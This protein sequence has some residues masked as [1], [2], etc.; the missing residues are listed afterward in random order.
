MY[1]ISYCGPSLGHSDL[2]NLQST[3]PKNGCILIWRLI[4]RGFYIFSSIKFQIKLCSLIA[5]PSYLPWT[6]CDQTS[7]CTTSYLYLILKWLIMTLRW[8][9]LYISLEN[10]HPQLWHHS[11]LGMIDF[12]NFESAL[13]EDSCLWTW[14]VMA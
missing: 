10:L 11:T 6:W 2:N 12:S 5:A 7:I 4:L 9:F 1:M 3:L 13:P 8:F 14:L